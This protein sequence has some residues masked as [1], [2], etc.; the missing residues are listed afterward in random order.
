MI[1]IF[2][3]FSFHALIPISS[4]YKYFCERNMPF[5][6]QTYCLIST[7]EVDLVKRI[8]A[9]HAPSTRLESHV[10]VGEKIMSTASLP[11]SRAFITD[12]CR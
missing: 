6:C 8:N 12:I 10:E 5:S 2:G 3:V 7:I 1:L 4:N 9:W 11:I